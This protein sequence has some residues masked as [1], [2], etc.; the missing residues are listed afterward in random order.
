VYGWIFQKLHSCGFFLQAELVT[1]LFGTFMNF[2]F[3]RLKRREGRR[4]GAGRGVSV[5][6]ET[7]MKN[8]KNTVIMDETFFILG[9]S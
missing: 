9:L 2:F 5:W 7:F 4:K 3:V 8:T 6:I 1:L